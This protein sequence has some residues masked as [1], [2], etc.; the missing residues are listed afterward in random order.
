MNKVSLISA[1]LLTALSLSIAITC[2]FF[3]CNLI[4]SQAT[5]SR[6][7]ETLKM[8]GILPAVLAVTGALSS[9]ILNAYGV[10]TQQ[11]VE[12]MLCGLLPTAA[13]I[14]IVTTGVLVTFPYF[15]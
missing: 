2:S 4:P 1:V 6:I 10:I 8:I 13:I 12:G 9:T 11:T 3:D 5:H 7:M 14:L 15:S